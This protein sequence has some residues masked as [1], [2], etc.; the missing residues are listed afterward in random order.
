MSFTT[1]KTGHNKYWS[2]LEGDLQCPTLLYLWPQ[3]YFTA[4]KTGHNKYWSVLQVALGPRLAP[5][6]LYCVSYFP[7]KPHSTHGHLYL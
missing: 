3:M 1:Q 6:M 7:N 2:V 5:A 4:Q